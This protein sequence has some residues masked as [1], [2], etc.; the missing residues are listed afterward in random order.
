MQKLTKA[1]IASQ[2]KPLDWRT[3]ELHPNVLIAFG[4]KSEYSIVNNLTGKHSLIQ[5]FPNGY[6]DV[7]EIHC[8]IDSL[9]FHAAIYE[10]TY[11][12]EKFEF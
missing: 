6:S 9:K 10:A 5:E 4:V 7:L 12:L 8:N 2:L 11:I 1:Q 3:H